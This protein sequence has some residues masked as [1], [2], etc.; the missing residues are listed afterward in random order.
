[1]REYVVVLNK[2]VDYDQFWNEIENVSPADGFVPSR[3]VEIINNRDGS[4][5]SCHYLL[6]D[7]EATTLQQ[8]PR[9]LS[10]EIPVDQRDDVQI[11]L[12]ASQN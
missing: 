9:I 6:S 12:F 5:R 8:D 7:E 4:L 10:V 3:K 1:M 11:G 2:G